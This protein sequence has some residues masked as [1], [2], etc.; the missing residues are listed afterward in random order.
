VIHTYKDTEF[1]RARVVGP[2]YLGSLLFVVSIPFVAMLASGSLLRTVN[3]EFLAVLIGVLL[4]TSLTGLLIYRHHTYGRC[5]EIRL[6]DDGTCDLETKRR[7]IRLHA[8]EILSVQYRPETDEGS[9]YYD[10]HYRGGK[11][12]VTKEMSGFNDFLTRLKTLNPAVD[13]SSFPAHSRLDFG[14]P[15]SEPP[16][17]PDRFRQRALFPILVI[18]ALVWLASQTLPGR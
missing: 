18:A 10:I 5:S 14:T 15:A 13:L 2:P 9:E 8:N 12:Q 3:A 4:F 17:R 7:V 11:L 6:G 16:L 1:V